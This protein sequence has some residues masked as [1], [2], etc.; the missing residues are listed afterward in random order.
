M[1]RIITLLPILAC[2][3]NNAHAFQPP[4][5]P[6]A[7]FPKT[8]PIFYQR[9]PVK[10][11]V[12]ATQPAMPT[13]QLAAASSEECQCE[14]CK[15]QRLHSAVAQPQPVRHVAHT[16]HTRPA[17]HTQPQPQRTSMIS[18]L[19]Q[20]SHAQAQPQ[21]I[22]QPEF[23]YADS[24]TAVCGDICSTDSFC[25]CGMQPCECRSDRW[26]SLET[27]VWWTNGSS[28]PAL[29][30]QSQ[31]GT[32]QANAGILGLP[33]TTTVFGGGDLFD[34]A[35]A[36]FRVR[37]GKTL[38]GCS[39]IDFD[40]FRLGEQHESFLGASGGDPIL[41]RPFTDTLTGQQNSEL[42]GF[43]GVTTGQLR[44]QGESR[45][46]SAAAHLFRL[47][48]EEQSCDSGCDQ[49][50]AVIQV[51]P[52]FASLKESMFLEE[53]VTGSQTGV[54]NILVDSF[55]ADNAFL[56][57]EIGLQLERQTRN[58]FVRGSLALALGMTRQEL[59]VYGNT[60][61]I[62]A[63]GATTQFPGGLLAQ[64][65]NSGSFSQNRFSVMPQAELKVGYKTRWGWEITAGYNLFYWSKVLRATEQIDTNLNPN[66]LPP[67]VVPF[68]GSQ[69]PALV[70][71]ESGYLAHG[72]SFGLEK[73][74]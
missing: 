32:L 22:P 40:F 29:A 8:R 72:I 73:R 60:T 19:S 7:A 5:A 69:Q 65:T 15:S 38:D 4:Q 10:P 13:I 63:Q 47:A 12:A 37:G 26:L 68:T 51:G 59:E 42:V 49:F 48:E 36:G 24:G 21:L 34:S 33:T 18:R 45:L 43:P 16:S 27:L 9:T 39:G 56:G 41:T 62:T 20:V 30:T 14:Y 71:K 35:T 64:R 25:D 55:K 52:R 74:F 53:Y 61:R 46:Y 66:L 23:T 67:E 50:S 11:V 58:T 3:L 31:A 2:L 17:T 70:L 1:F 6:A 28:T 44:Y 57:G 54:Q